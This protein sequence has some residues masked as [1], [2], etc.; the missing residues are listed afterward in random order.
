MCPSC[1]GLVDDDLQVVGRALVLE[2]IAEWLGAGAH[3]WPWA[4]AAVHGLAGG[5]GELFDTEPAL[6]VVDVSWGDE[7]EG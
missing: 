3:D 4:P 1:Y 5:F 2:A 6:E 7:G